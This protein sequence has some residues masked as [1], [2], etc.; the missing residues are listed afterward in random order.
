MRRGFR[1][2]RANMNSLDKVR[3]P[4]PLWYTHKTWAEKLLIRVFN[5]GSAEEII[6]PENRGTNPIPGTNSKNQDTHLSE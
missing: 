3:N 1:R 6:T 2:Y 5:F 4:T